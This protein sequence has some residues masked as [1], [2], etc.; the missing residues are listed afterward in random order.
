MK[1][2]LIADIHENVELLR[3][4]IDW[5]RA[6]NVDQI[7]VLGDVFASAYTGVLLLLP[8]VL[9]KGVHAVIARY[10]DVS[11]PPPLRDLLRE[12]PHP[13]ADVGQNQ[14]HPAMVSDTASL[15][16]FSFAPAA[17]LGDADE[18]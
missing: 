5:F 3:E 4:A 6:E 12:R 10:L 14:S 13:V 1:L 16:R 7:V 8:A 11:A 18:R 15:S 9:F 2:G 17:P